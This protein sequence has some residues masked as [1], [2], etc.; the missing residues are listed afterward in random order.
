MLL[1]GDFTFALLAISLWS[2]FTQ[3]RLFV[4]VMEGAGRLLHSRQ[5]AVCDIVSKYPVFRL[6]PVL[7]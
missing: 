3:I 1:Y 7:V 2:Y 4:L 5:R 6:R